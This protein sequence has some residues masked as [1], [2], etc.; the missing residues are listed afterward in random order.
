MSY[1]VCSLRKL[2]S[3]AWLSSRDSTCNVF[4]YVEEPTSFISQNILFAHAKPKE[5]FAKN[6][7]LCESAFI[8][9]DIC[10]AISSLELGKSAGIEGLSN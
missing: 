3:C 6:R 4:I 5:V 10:C 9:N 7:Q 2:I 1:K 8:L